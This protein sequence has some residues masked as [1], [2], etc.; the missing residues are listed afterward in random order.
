[1]FVYWRVGGGF[2]HVFLG[3]SLFLGKIPMLS[4]VFQMGCKHQPDEAVR[5]EI[6]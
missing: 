4:N 3:S 5:V 2:K 1:M 6:G